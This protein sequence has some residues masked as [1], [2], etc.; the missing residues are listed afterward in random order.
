MNKIKRETKL[1]T[2]NKHRK[3]L[4]PC[5]CSMIG[6]YVFHIGQIL[7]GEFVRRL[8]ASKAFRMNRAMQIG[9]LPAETRLARF[10]LFYSHCKCGVCRLYPEPSL[11]HCYV[12]LIMLQSYLLTARFNCGCFVIGSGFQFSVQRNRAFQK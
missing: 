1:F 10:H 2:R 9:R 6:F 4:D 11:K 8:E 12:L 5:S 3:E 7:P